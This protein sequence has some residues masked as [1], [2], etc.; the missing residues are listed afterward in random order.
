MI[1][2]IKPKKSEFPSTLQKLTKHR[3]NAATLINDGDKS[4][5]ILPTLPTVKKAN[6]Q[7]EGLV[8]DLNK[9]NE[10]VSLQTKPNLL[11]KAERSRNNVSFN[12]EKNLKNRHGSS[13]EGAVNRAMFNPYGQER[14]ILKTMESDKEDQVPPLKISRTE[15]QLGPRTLDIDFS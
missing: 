4:I 5:T 14:P 6:I 9:I 13:F 8:R 15:S 10:H 7:G 12:T 1:P 11:E 2:K 3:P